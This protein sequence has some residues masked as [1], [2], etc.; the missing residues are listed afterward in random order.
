M[1]CLLVH[2]YCQGGLFVHNGFVYCDICEREVGKEE[3]LVVDD[4]P[5]NL[6]DLVGATG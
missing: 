3:V 1:S 6:F 2:S 4:A 5:R